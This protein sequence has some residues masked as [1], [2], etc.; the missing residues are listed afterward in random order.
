MNMTFKEYKIIILV[1]LAVYITCMITIF[2][3]CREMIL[4]QANLLEVSDAIQELNDKIVNREFDQRNLFNE[5]LQHKKGLEQENLSAIIGFI[6]M[7]GGLVYIKVIFMS[8]GNS[9]YIG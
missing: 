4:L 9:P 3:L 8:L 1:L 7:V 5:H 2:V 6:V